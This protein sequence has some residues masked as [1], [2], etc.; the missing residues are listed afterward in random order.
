LVSL[1]EVEGVH[2]EPDGSTSFSFSL[3][4]LLN[5][6]SCFREVV[7]LAEVEEIHA[8]LDGRTFNFARSFN[9]LGSATLVWRLALTGGCWRYPC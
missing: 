8:E 7:S 6:R 5:R 1:A 2:A 4:T 9:V 3:S